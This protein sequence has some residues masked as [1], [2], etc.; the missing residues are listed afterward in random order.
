MTRRRELNVFSL[1]FLDI[2]SCGFGAV[3]LIFVLINQ[4]S[5]AEQQTAN[6]DLILTATD[7]QKRLTEE[8][9]RLDELQNITHRASR[10]TR[11]ANQI[12]EQLR[13]EMTELQTRIDAAL[14]SSADKSA[15]VEKLQVELAIL[16][17]NASS[18]LQQLDQTRDQGASLRSVAGDGQRQYLTG[19]NVGGKQVLILIDSSASMLHQSIVNAIRLS[20]APNAEKKAA[21]KWQ[22]AVRTV[23][24]ITANLAQDAQLSIVAFNT[25]LISL[26]KDNAWIS[27]SDQA[28]VDHAL[29]NL[30]ALAPAGGTALF[31]PFA[32]INQLSPRP[33]NIFLIVDGLPTQGQNPSTRTVISSAERAKL[34]SA[35]VAELPQN[36]PMNI[37]LLPMEGDPLATPSYWILAQKTGGA[38]LSPAK[39]WP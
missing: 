7:L 2:M 30:Y 17:Q 29:N 25:E 10:E 8:Q 33:D 5:V 12:T 13:N 37:I 21:T 32:L 4:G 14:R 27:V 31:P 3:I 35:A 1:S 15:L 11:L 34:F 26:V 24:W 6:L 19:L 36:I 39:D 18:Q 28:A 23:D 22:R 9:A 16:E 38:F 20:L